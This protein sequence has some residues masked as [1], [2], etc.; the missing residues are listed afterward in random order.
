MA[1]RRRSSTSFFSPCSRTQ[2]AAAWPQRSNTVKTSNAS[3]AVM[4]F[5]SGVE[6]F[7]HLRV[8]GVARGLRALREARTDAG[9]DEAP[10][11]PSVGVRA[12]ALI[13]EQLLDH[14]R[15]AFH[16][17]DLADPGDFA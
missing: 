1:A 8:D 5:L 7:E 11:D 10:D 16:P 12:L 15:V 6:V 13:R 2:M 3:R 17:D 9:R 4:R 14:D